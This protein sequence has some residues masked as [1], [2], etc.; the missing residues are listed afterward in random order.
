[1]L[2]TLDG[3]KCNYC[4]YSTRKHA[5]NAPRL[6]VLIPTDRTMTPDEYEPCA[7]RMADYIG[8]SMA[9]P[10]TFEVSRLMYWPSC[11]SDSEFVFRTADEPFASVDSLLASYKDWHDISEWP[12]VPGSFSYQKL[13][14]KQGDPEAKPGIVGAFCR[15]YDIYRAIDELLPGIYEAVDNEKDRYTY[16]GGSTTGGAIVYDNGKVSVQPSRYGSLLRQAGKQL[17]HGEATQVRRRGRR[18]RCEYASEPSA[19]L[20]ANAGVCQQP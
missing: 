4:V 2:A 17:R 11:C 9:D 5:P 3:L 14:V 1:M 13:A 16:L 12:Q 8:I 18:E 19:I 6:R 7:R 10:T 20:Q 15:T